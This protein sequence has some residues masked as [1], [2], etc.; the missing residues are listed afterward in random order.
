MQKQIL[1]NNLH[2]I[3]VKLVVMVTAWPTSVCRRCFCAWSW[4]RA[5]LYS[6]SW[7]CSPGTFLWASSFSCSFTQWEQI[8]EGHAATCTVSMKH[9]GYATLART[10]LAVN[11]WNVASLV[12]FWGSLRAPKQL[13]PA[14]QRC[15]MY[16]FT[17]QST[18]S[19]GFSARYRDMLQS[20]DLHLVHLVDCLTLV[21]MVLNISSSI[22]PM[23]ACLCFFQVDTS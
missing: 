15:F 7:L 19:F 16:V 22:E 4:Q 3:C 13:C 9:E 14:W 23:L 8:D 11:V 6:S 5:L 10:L 2:T 1:T 12:H 18:E 21:V 17:I 20:S